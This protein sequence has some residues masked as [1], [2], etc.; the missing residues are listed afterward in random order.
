MPLHVPV[1][2]RARTAETSERR[3]TVTAEARVVADGSLV[4]DGRA[5]FALIPRHR[6]GL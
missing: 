1:E 3:S 5:V 6:L 4:A 2:V